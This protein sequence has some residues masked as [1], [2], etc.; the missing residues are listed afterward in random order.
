MEKMDELLA[1]YMLEEAST[2]EIRIID[3]WVKA[4]DA[5][6]KYF[7]HFKLIW[8]TSKSLKIESDLNIDESWLE[9]KQMANSQQAQ[10]TVRPMFNTVRWMKIAAIWLVLFGAAALIYVNLKPGK[11]Q[12]L[13]LQAMD[14]VTIDTLSDGSVITLNKHS[15]ITFPD[16]FTGDTRE[17]TLNKGEAFFNIAPNKAKPF[18]IHINNAVV[19]VVGTSFNIKTNASKTEVIVETGIVQVINTVQQIKR[20]VIVRLTPKQKADIDHK[21]GVIKKVT[22]T[23]RLYNY[24]LTN[25]IVANKTPLWRVVQVLNDAY[26]ANIVIDNKDIANKTLNT[27]LIIGSLNENLEIIRQTFNVQIIH[28]ANKTIIQ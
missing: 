6:L 7:N 4:D 27:T 11:P 9:F 1:K 24:Y 26:A 15:L 28:K 17:I 23:D 16:K 8:E 13:T 21:S 18:L 2:E 5:N 25:Q 20:K 19:K 10:A 22:N 3:E 14:R 12:L